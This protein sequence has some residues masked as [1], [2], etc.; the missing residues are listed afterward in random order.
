MLRPAVQGDA[1]RIISLLAPAANETVGMLSL[2]RNQKQAEAICAESDATTTDLAA[3]SFEPPPGSRRQLLFVL[4]DNDQLVGLTG[5]TFKFDYP[6]L[7]FQLATGRQGQGI[8]MT[9]VSEAWSRSEL[10]SSFIAPTAR[11]QGHGTTLSRGRFMLLHLVRHQVPRT[12]VSHLR[13]TFDDAGNAP[14]WLTVRDAIGPEWPTSTDAEQA[15]ADHPDRLL[16]LAGHILPLEPEALGSLGVVNAA[17]K[18]AFTLLLNE[19]LLPNGMYDPVDGGPTVAGPLEST[20]THH[21][22]RHGRTRIATPDNPV[23]ALVTT[24]SVARFRATRALVSLDDHQGTVT[25]DA[26]T[27]A[28]LRVENGDVVT[29]APLTAP[30]APPAPSLHPPTVPTP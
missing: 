8:V 19:G 4:E 13:G 24:S 5:L 3:R 22:R 14:F 6:N 16:E 20:A 9:S 27:A 15:L 28:R 11:G 23:D 2:P 12:V 18:P 10:D 29:V 25:V 30:A 17:S 26:A 21:T 1:A 7:V